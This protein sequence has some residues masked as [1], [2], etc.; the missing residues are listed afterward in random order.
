M[1]DAARRAARRVGHRG[2]FL[3][4][5]AVLDLGFGYSLIGEPS[6]VQRVQNLTLPVVAWGWIW[7]AVGVVCLAFVPVSQ[8]RDTPAF[9][10]AAA[11]KFGW[12]AAAIRA[13][14]LMPTPR[15]WVV[16]LIFGTLLGAVLSTASWAEPPWGRSRDRGDQRV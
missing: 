12:V 8:Q 2:V 5:L 4:F 15:W 3:L 14:I 11:L 13:G 16:P 10:V 6:E 7:V 9:G 1:P